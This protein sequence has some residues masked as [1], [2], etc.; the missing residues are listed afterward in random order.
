MPN[1]RIWLKSLTKMLRTLDE[2]HGNRQE[3]QKR[4]NEWE[5]EIFYQAEIGLVFKDTLR[6]STKGVQWKDKCFPLASITWVKWGAVS[7]SVNGIPTGTDYTIAVG[8]NRSSAVIETRKNEIYSTFTDKLWR[9][10]C[11]RLLTEYLESLKSGKSITIGGAV[12]DDNGVQ[13]TKHKF[14]EDEPAYRNWGEV[15]YGSVGG[16]LV[17]TAQDDKKVY[18][19]FPYLTTPN[20]HILEAMIRLSFKEWTGRLSGL[21]ND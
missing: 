17:I 10:V 1:C 12:I 6:I 9:A 13:L 8:D 7:R 21:L 20:A 11:V 15:T 18:V 14:W 3:A 16:S 4:S 5:K 19:D 2:I